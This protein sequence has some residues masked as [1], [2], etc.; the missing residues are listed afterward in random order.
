M[1]TILVQQQ[2]LHGRAS[3]DGENLGVVSTAQDKDSELDCVV[4][5]F[6]GKKQVHRLF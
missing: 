4:L 1:W 5:V 6:V 3:I 2:Q